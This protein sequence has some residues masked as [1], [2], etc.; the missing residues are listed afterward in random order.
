MS[1][2]MKCRRGDAATWISYDKSSNMFGRLGRDEILQ[3]V[4]DLDQRFEMIAHKA[5]TRS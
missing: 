4:M 1:D 5:L 2:P 3:T